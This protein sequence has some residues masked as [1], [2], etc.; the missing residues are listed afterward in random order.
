MVYIFALSFLYFFSTTDSMFLKQCILNIANKFPFFAFKHFKLTLYFVDNILK[1]P[2]R[3]WLEPKHLKITQ[4]FRK[5]QLRSFLVSSYSV[6]KYRILYSPSQVLSVVDLNG[7]LYFRIWSCRSRSQQV[8]MTLDNTCL[9]PNTKGFL[10]Y[11]II[12]SQ[13]F[14]MVNPKH[15]LHCYGMRWRSQQA[16]MTST[17]LGNHLFAS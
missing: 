6:K 5:L 12:S 13:N 17:D 8:P 11:F 15:T 7:I 1:S 14:P 10:S 9:Q 2:K 3:L 4:L 16:Q